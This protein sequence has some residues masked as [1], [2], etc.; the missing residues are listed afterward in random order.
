M[1]ILTR[2]TLIS[3]SIAWALPSDAENVTLA[4]DPNSEPDLAGYR[5]HYGTESG[6]Y[7]QIIDVG[8]V[9][10]TTISGLTRG[11]TYFA[12]GTAYNTSDLESDYS[13]EIQFTIATPAS[14]PDTDGDGLPDHF[15]TAYGNGGDLDPLS[16]LDGDGLSALAEYVHG[17]DPTAPLVG[18]LFEI[19][20]LSFSGADYLCIRY[21]ANPAALAQIEVKVQRRVDLDDPDGWV[22]GE[23]VLLS[24]LPST[25][26]PGMLEIMERSPAPLGSVRMEFFRLRHS[27]LEPQNATKSF[28]SPRSYRTVGDKRPGSPAR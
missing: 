21:L 13:Q 12:A 28:P 25:T 11:T 4:W 27:F 6:T 16:D 18:Q 23:T 2:F 3:L 8:N 15:E 26:S 10:A 5:I 14:E 17:L 9:T 24:S 19:E 7:T 22:T 20:V 1:K